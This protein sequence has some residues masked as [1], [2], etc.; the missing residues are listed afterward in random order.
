MQLHVSEKENNSSK[1]VIFSKE[2]IFSWWFLEQIALLQYDRLL[3][4]VIFYD[5]FL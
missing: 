2:I 5:Y 1:E 3:K 4:K